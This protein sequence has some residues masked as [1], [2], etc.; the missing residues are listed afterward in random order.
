MRRRTPNSGEAKRGLR[1]MS[2]PR[3]RIRR[4]PGCLIFRSS[5]GPRHKN[6]A[7]LPMRLW[8]SMIG[9]FGRDLP[10]SGRTLQMGQRRKRNAGASSAF[11]RASESLEKVACSAAASISRLLLGRALRRFDLDVSFV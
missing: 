4:A 6:A 7:N 10:S 8:T 11:Y 3:P 5:E 9:Y 2:A 1:L